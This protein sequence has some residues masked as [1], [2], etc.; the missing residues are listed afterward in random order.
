MKTN[1]NNNN[2]LKKITTTTTKKG[3]PIFWDLTAFSPLLVR[4]TAFWGRFPTE[5]S[6]LHAQQVDGKKCKFA[7]KSIINRALFRAQAARLSRTSVEAEEIKLRQC[8]SHFC[9]CLND[10]S[11]NKNVCQRSR[12]ACL[13]K[14]LSR[15][16][17]STWRRNHLEVIRADNQ[18]CIN[19]HHDSTPVCIM[20]Q[21]GPL[22]WRCY[23]YAP[24]AQRSALIVR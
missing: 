20:I 3:W 17:T 8:C 11:K 15:S 9:R 7:L 12:C 16:N 21:S 1:D 5:V 13:K 23:N 18:T 4:D 2:I 6:T 19:N 22:C 14:K 24:Y 10:K